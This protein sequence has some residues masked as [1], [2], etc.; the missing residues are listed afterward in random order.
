MMNR[1]NRACLI[2]IMIKFF[3]GLTELHPESEIGVVGF[4]S[5][6]FEGTDGAGISSGFEI[7]T[8]AGS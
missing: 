3:W 4:C 6:T 2:K 1:S 5:G 7:E 8:I